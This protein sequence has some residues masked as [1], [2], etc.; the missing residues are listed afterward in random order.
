MLHL[1]GCT[2]EICSHYVASRDEN[3]IMCKQLVGKDRAGGSYNH[4]KLLYSTQ[5]KTG[6][7]CVYCLI[8]PHKRH[9]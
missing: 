2:L 7:R 1:V 9:V 8:N 6:I 4:F 5:M 3:I